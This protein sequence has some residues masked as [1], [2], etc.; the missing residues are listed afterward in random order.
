MPAAGWNGKFMGIGNGGW[1]GQISTFAM[2]VPLAQGYATASTDTGHEG[3]SGSSF[4]LGHTEK[5]TDYSYRAVHEMTLKAKAIIAAYYGKAA[6][7]SYWT[8]CSLGGQQG[9]KE[10]QLYPADYDGIIAG[11]PT[12][13]RTHLHAWQLHAGYASLKGDK[14]RYIPPSKYGLIHAAVLRACDTLDGVK[15]GILS[16]PLQCKN[17]GPTNRQGALPWVGAWNR[18]GMGRFD[19]RPRA[20]GARD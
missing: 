15:D 19:W 9:L 18:T 11:A 3:T 20:S 2:V 4:A 1:A 10:A 17:S 8:G 16:N 13:N 14:A 7:L 6:R 5:L 12:Y